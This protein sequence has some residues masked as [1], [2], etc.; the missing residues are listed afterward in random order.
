MIGFRADAET[1]AELTHEAKLQKKSVTDILQQRLDREKN[2]GVLEAQHQEV[3]QRL[4]QLEKITKTRVPKSKRISIG[5]S[6][7]EDA[8]ISNLAFE[9]RLSKAEFVRF[10]L[11]QMHQ[12]LQAIENNTYKTKQQPHMKQLIKR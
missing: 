5:F 9:A 10:S 4:Q 8:I 3:L 1:I 7:Q 11:R 2:Y 12:P 6:L